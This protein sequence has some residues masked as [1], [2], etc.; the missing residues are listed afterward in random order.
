M[1]LLTSTSDLIQVVTTPAVTSITV[2][3]SWLDN[4]SGT[5]TPGRTNTVP[6]TGATTTTVLASPG[7]STQRNLKSLIIFNT[8][9]SSSCTI[10]VQHTD[11]S[12][13]ETLFKYTLLA[14]E[15]IQYY[16][17]LGFQVIDASGGLKLSPATG[18]YLKTTIVTNTATTT[19]TTGTQT[20]NAFVTVVGG[21]GGGAGV[22]GNS[23]NS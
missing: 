8:H 19:F 23:G 15:T 5:I 22:A 21:G 4:A 12:N 20:G 16:D 13:V 7:S 2:H 17:T 9:A 10:T 18:R 11:G 14:G 6:I 3:A 1:I